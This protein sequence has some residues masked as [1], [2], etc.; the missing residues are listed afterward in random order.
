VVE[1]D[2]ASVDKLIDDLLAAIEPTDKRRVPLSAFVM[3]DSIRAAIMDQISKTIAAW[4]EEL[5]CDAMAF[6]ALGPAYLLSFAEFLLSSEGLDEASDSHPPARMRLSL[7]LRM[8]DKLSY[9][10]AFEG[11]KGPDGGLFLSVR[12][13]QQEIRAR[14]EKSPTPVL[15]G[16]FPIVS[17][18]VWK[19]LDS[20]IVRALEEI[21]DRSYTPEHFVE[22]VPV[23]MDLLSMFV[24][25]C[26]VYDLDSQEMHPADLVS[27]LNAGSCFKLGRMD[28]LY[29]IFGASSSQER[30]A[31]DAKYGNL[32]SKA[33]ELASTFGALE[34]G[35]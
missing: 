11:G 16:P 20:I 21:D 25:P 33:I 23:L 15:P 29:Q 10:V 1:I 19:T 32:I 34:V 31:V 26:V 8:M 30:H 18:S 5:V 24:P 9:S 4:I 14:I 6:S 35:S 12:R 13:R 7:L 28:S 22:E 2:Q 27:I 3:R 17:Q